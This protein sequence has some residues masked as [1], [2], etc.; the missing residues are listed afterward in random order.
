[1]WRLIKRFPVISYGVVTTALLIPIQLLANF[2]NG[3]D[4][5]GLG[6]AAFLLWMVWQVLAFP[7]TLAKLALAHAHGGVVGPYDVA[8][9]YGAGAVIFI[10]GELI[11]QLI[12]RHS[13]TQRAS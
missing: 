10:F 13:E 4:D 3:Y 2:G 12:R 5:R 6:T 8:L 11:W 7:Y 9:M 1:M